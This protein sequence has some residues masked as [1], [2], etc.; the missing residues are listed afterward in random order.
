M[1]G[2]GTWEKDREIPFEFIDREIGSSKLKIKTI[3]EYAQQVT[4]IT[5]YSFSHH[6]SAAWREWKRVFKFGMV[7]LT[8]IVVNLAVLTLLMIAGISGYIALFFAII[9]AILNNFIWNDLWTFSDSARRMVTSTWERLRLFYIVSA[10]G[11]VINYGVAI[12]LTYFVGMKIDLADLI[13][14]LI[15]FIWNFLIN[16]RYTWGRK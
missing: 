12:L 10:G 14:I 16:R 5:L 3:I 15:G 11:A 13:G 2:K 7:G 8:G 4:D 6:H 9:L 1:L